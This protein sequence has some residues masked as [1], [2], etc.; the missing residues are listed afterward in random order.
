MYREFGHGLGRLRAVFSL[1]RRTFDFGG[2][3]DWQE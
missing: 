2:E 1:A 3:Q